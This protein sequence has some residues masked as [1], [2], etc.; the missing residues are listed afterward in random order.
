MLVDG[1]PYNQ[2]ASAESDYYVE[3]NPD[4]GFIT[5]IVKKTT[6][7]MVLDPEMLL[8]FYSIAIPQKT[9]VPVFDTVET[10]EIGEKEINAMFNYVTP[11][12]TQRF[13]Y[14][15]AFAAAGSAFFLAGIIAHIVYMQRKRR[16]GPSAGYQAVEM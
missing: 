6:T 2:Q 1:K 16:A 4:S 10:T 13:A 3:I 8:P 7:Y 11:L 9:L 12:N 5:N 14:I 15:V